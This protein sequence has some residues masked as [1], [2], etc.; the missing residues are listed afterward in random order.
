LGKLVGVPLASRLF[1]LFQP[2][3]LA[4]HAAP[5]NRVRRSHGLAP[6]AGLHDV[7]TWADTTL[8]ADVPELVVTDHLPGN[9]AYIGPI[10]WSPDVP[11][12]GWW[13]ELSADDTCIYVTVG[14]SGQVAALAAILEGLAKLPVTVLLATAGRTASGPLP[15]NVRVANYLPGSEA[16]RRSAVVICNG[17]SATVYQA[18]ADGVPVLGLPSNLDQHL[19]MASVTEVG[20]G[21]SI[22]AEAA[23]AVSVREA[24]QQLLTQRRFADGAKKVSE[25]FAAF[26]A[27]RRFEEALRRLPG[28]SY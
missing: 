18:L 5:L 19:T 14:S 8:Y 22:R 4:Q 13:A 26:P 25:W 27:E 24:V 15:A 17:G 7:Y 6:F 1:N 12:P 10:L 23:S 16:A 2:F 9:H 20:A 11:K 3:V 28:A 21:L